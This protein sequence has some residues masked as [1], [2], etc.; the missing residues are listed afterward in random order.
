MEKITGY[1]IIDLNIDF[2]YENR[3]QYDN[4]QLFVHEITHQRHKVI[5]EH[6]SVVTCISLDNNI[7]TK[8]L[9]LRISGPHV[10]LFRRL[11]N[12]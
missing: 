10:V 11:V 8:I 5:D 4:N 6:H 12:T 1:V 3:C 9:Y 7:T 2:L